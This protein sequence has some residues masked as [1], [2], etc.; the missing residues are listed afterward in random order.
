MGFGICG[1]ERWKDN[2]IRVLKEYADSYLK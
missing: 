1:E 2:G